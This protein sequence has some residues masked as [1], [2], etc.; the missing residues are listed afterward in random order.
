MNN[1]QTNIN[2]AAS[3]IIIRAT[4]ANKEMLMPGIINVKSPKPDRSSKQFSF[5]IST[6]GTNK[7]KQ[8]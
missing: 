4:R 1:K 7:H 2:E 5:Q 3:A 6:T 8:T